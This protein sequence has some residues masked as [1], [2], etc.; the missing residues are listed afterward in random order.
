MDKLDAHRRSGVGLLT[1]MATHTSV[2]KEPKRILMNIGLRSVGTVILD[3]LDVN[4]E[5][6]EDVDVGLG[7]I[8]DGDVAVFDEFSIYVELPVED[9]QDVDLPGLQ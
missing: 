8:E 4:F 7:W 2:S 9:V 3:D 5:D 6:V 1:S